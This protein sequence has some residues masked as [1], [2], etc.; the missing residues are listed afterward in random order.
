LLISGNA[1][2]A[3]GNS[4][5]GRSRGR[6]WGGL[7]SLEEATRY[8]LMVDE[9][10][11]WQTIDRHGLAGPA[12]DRIQLYRPKNSGSAAALSHFPAL[13]EG[14]QPFPLGGHVLKHSP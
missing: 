9:L 8:A 1:Y 7:P 10:L 3:L 11:A 14:R 13:R 5:L 6:V 4:S 12:H 2:E